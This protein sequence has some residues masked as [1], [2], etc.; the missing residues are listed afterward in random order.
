MREFFKNKTIFLSMTLSNNIQSFSHF[1]NPT[2][3]IFFL[4]IINEMVVNSNS[5]SKP[6]KI[7]LS[8]TDRS[9]NYG[10]TSKYN[11]PLARSPIA[12]IQKLHEKL[13]RYQNHFNI[14]NSRGPCFYQ[15]ASSHNILASAPRHHYTIFLM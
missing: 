7:S 11:Y 14:Q 15:L 5:S 10:V 3:Y 9:L 1:F 12:L 8:K 6:L 4:A 13:A 2:T